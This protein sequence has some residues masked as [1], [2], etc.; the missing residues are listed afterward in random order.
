MTL[1]SLY[2]GYQ[3]YTIY[4]SIRSHFTSD[5]DY[6]KYGGKVRA[7]KDAYIKRRDKFFFAKLQRKYNSEELIQLFVACFITD[8]KSW[9]GSLVSEASERTYTDWKKRV[10]SLSYVFEQDCH[11][12][13]QYLEKNNLTFNDLFST[14][15]IPPL[16]L[17]LHLQKR[18]SLETLAIMDSILNFGRRWTKELG[19]DDFIWSH[20]KF[21]VTKYSPFLHVDTEHYKKILRQVFT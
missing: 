7:S 9:S 3:A 11:A 18:V 16:L 8:D 1:T 21:T 4:L 5:Y 17:T 10:Q 2:D 19:N 15:E 20:L 14:S 12:L 13:Q 6:F